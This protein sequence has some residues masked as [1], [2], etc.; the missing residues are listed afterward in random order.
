MKNVLITLI[1]MGG[2]LSVRAY[3]AEKSLS[4]SRPDTKLL[5]EKSS[6]AKTLAILPEGTVVTLLEGGNFLFK[7]V[8]TAEGKIG[9]IPYTF[10]NDK[11]A[12]SKVR[13]VNYVRKLTRPKSEE[14]E[15]TRSRSTNVVMGIRGLA[16]TDDL[17][18]SR[19]NASRPDIK[20]V[21]EME[22][23]V[24]SKND[25]DAHFELIVRENEGGAVP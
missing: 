2:V 15:G 13:I 11:E 12:S 9:Y 7:K 20:S 21:I 17:A 10:L 1:V 5:A 3:S 18:L 25:L 16:T 4:V 6:K 22:D 19:I 23:R 24:V 8:Q 14:L